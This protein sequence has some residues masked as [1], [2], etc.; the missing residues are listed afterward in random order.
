[1]LLLNS[2]NTSL[3]VWSRTVDDTI[4]IVCYEN[5]A[6]FVVFNAVPKQLNHASISPQVMQSISLVEYENVN[7]ITA[8]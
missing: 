8:V 5:N 7:H 3:F 4:F 2:Q 6:H 1:M